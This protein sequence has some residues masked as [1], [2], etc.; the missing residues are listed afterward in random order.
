VSEAP[1]QERRPRASLR[2]W[3]EYGALRALGGVLSLFPWRVA[4]AVGAAVG[5][6]GYRPLR[7]RRRVVDYQL[8]LAF[9]ELDA[10]A[11]RRIA[12][13]SYEHLGRV[14][15]EMAIVSKL[16]RGAALDLFHPAV[17][18]EHI[19]GP[20]S[21]GRGVIM[22]SGHLG[23]WEL[24]G[25]Y[26]VERG[27]PID[28]VVRRQTNPLVDRYITRSRRRLGWTIIP[29][30]DAVSRIPRSIAAGHLVPM[31][32]DQGV[33]GLASTFVPFFGRDA[34]TPKGPALLALRLGAPCVLTAIIRQPD[35]RYCMHF[36][37]VPV[38]NTG[39][40]ERDVDTIV[41]AYTRQLEAWVR[42]YPEQYL[43]Q[44]RRWRRRPDG[45]FEGPS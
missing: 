4:S 37:P 15:V 2:H 32:A 20:I 8:A 14:A 9:P 24:A 35:G 21:Q 6:L 16:K 42:L 22:V 43:W 7:I 25:G 12:L 39:D 13:R 31:L 10:R 11:R 41:A 38:V 45:S 28:V 33:K 18:W 44:H 34:R 29:D 30:R 26:L 17:G 3:L 27:V 19:A 40:R 5:T 23:N 1:P 36:E